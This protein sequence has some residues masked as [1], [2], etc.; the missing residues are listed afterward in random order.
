MRRLILL[1]SIL[2]LFLM[3]SKPVDQRLV[4]LTIINKSGE[5]LFIT[6]DN[7][8]PY[9]ENNVTYSFTIPPG[10]KTKPVVRQFTIYR[11]IY[12]MVF[13][14]IREWDPVYQ[15]SPC[16][17]APHESVLDATKNQR[18]TFTSCNQTPPP[19]GEDTMNKVWQGITVNRESVRKA[20]TLD[21]LNQ[22][23][24]LFLNG[25]YVIDIPPETD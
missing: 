2:A 16:N 10:T 20:F 14:Y 15:Y 7:I 25:C 21:R 18:F 19:P 11:D 8:E 24:P 6:L 1:T 23:N 13:Y 9:Y 4:K 22:F 17:Q 12:N 3:G 5:E